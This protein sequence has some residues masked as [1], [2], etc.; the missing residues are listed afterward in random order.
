MN[1]LATICPCGHAAHLHPSPDQQRVRLEASGGMYTVECAGTNAM[2][3]I[4]IE[5][6]ACRCTTDRSQVIACG[7]FSSEATA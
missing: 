7:Q 2:P 1:P 5:F 6:A 3:E 4:G